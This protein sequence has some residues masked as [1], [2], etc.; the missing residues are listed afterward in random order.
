MATSNQDPSSTSDVKS[1]VNSMRGATNE[2]A[3]LARV[4][5]KL[6]ESMEDSSNAA[7]DKAAVALEELAKQS[8][9]LEEAIKDEIKAHKQAPRELAKTADR[10]AHHGELIMK[11]N[12]KYGKQLN[13]AVK[14]RTAATNLDKTD[15]NNQRKERANAL[16][17]E[18]AIRKQVER[19]LSALGEKAAYA[20]NNL[21]AAAAEAKKNVDTFTKITNDLNKPASKIGRG[22]DMMHSKV[23]TSISGLGK[24]SAVMALTKKA[25]T[26]L[27]DQSVKLANKGLLGSMAQLNISAL[28]LKMTADEFEAL[29]SS[30]RDLVALMGGGAQGIENFEK[31]LDQSA[32]GLEIFGKEGKKAA[33]AILGGFNRAGAG[34]MSS[35]AD[36]SKAYQDS[37]K[38]LNKQFKLFNGLFGD[39][40]EQFAALYEQQLKSEA[41]QARIIAGDGKTVALQMKEII[42]RTETLKLMGLN[43]EQIVAMSKRVDE[44]FNPKENRQGEAQT[45]R[46]AAR[47]ALQSG[48]QEIMGDDPALAAK[49]QDFVKSGEAAKFQ[50][51]SG[52]DKKKYMTDNAELFKGINKMEEMIAAKRDKDGGD[53]SFKGYLFTDRMKAAG[54]EW[55]TMSDTG[56]DLN[57]AKAQGYDQTPEGRMKLAAKGFENT[58]SDVNGET[59]ALGK[60][61]GKLREAVDLTTA[62]FNNP[63]STA[64]AALTTGLLFTS[65]TIKTAVS[66]AAESI[67]KTGRMMTSGIKGFMKGIW[68]FAKK[69]PGLGI[70]FDLAE[71]ALD[72][73]STSTEDYEKRTGLTAGDSFWGNVGVRATGALTDLGAVAAKNL[74]FGAWDPSKNFAD[75]QANAAKTAGM[76]APAAANL[77]NATKAPQATTGV[78]TDNEA[79]MRKALIDKGITDQ[80]QQAMLMGQLSHE[81]SGFTRLV[82]G[83]SRNY[84]NQYE[85]RKSLGNDVEGDGYKYRGRGFIQLTGKA[86]YTDA[87]KA[88]G[89]DLLN[90]PDLAADPE[91]ASKIAAWYVTKGRRG[92][93]PAENAARGDM[94]GLTKSINGGLNGLDDRIARTNRYMGSVST[95]TPPLAPPTSP[96]LTTP[97]APIDLVAQTEQQKRRALIDKAQSSQSSMSAP[98]AV[99]AGDKGPVVGELEK[100]TGLLSTLVGLMSR[101]QS[102]KRGFQL[103]QQSGISVAS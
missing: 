7:V 49:I 100:Q 14:K 9:I 57:M 39:T 55:S 52:E 81:S 75:K 60:S 96:I 38:P 51:M 33:A 42:A 70:L 23:Q 37:I 25:F 91:I 59:T 74:T 2:L 62:V 8:N 6:E 47:Q 95:A 17:A 19:D 80:K 101:P 30:N 21:S 72:V 86:N 73:K 29:V 41:L 82:E 24:F 88:L 34:L 32:V 27:Y 77:P 13:D 85:G 83:G 99:Q 71:T 36:I 90:N 58:L 64:L 35:N 1:F 79:L 45:Q 78:R 43:N 15:I 5:R 12:S 11:A 10:I 93:S 44:L 31:I 61:F 89:I 63:F 92:G 46:I 98:T 48:A 102:S 53:T 94:I 28:K 3:R 67:I 87:G 18:R 68:A 56:K 66:K 97:Q 76:T 40:A 54:K 4:T 20:A 69:I 26:E 84:F 50:R 22:L 16:R 103:D 65:T